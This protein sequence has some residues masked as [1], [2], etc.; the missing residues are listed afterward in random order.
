MEEHLEVKIIGPD[1]K[2]VDETNARV[3]ARGPLGARSA[4]V[5]LPNVNTRGCSGVAAMVA[6]RVSLARHPSGA[7]RVENV[8]A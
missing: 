3:N 2:S 4:P 6:C 1:G 5:D 7:P 8:S